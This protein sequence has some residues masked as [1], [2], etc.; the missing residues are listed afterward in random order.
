MPIGFT[1]VK[2]SASMRKWCLCFM[3]EIL[4]LDCMLVYVLQFSVDF[5]NLV[6]S[7][8]K[9]GSKCLICRLWHIF[10]F[11][12]DFQGIIVCYFLHI[13]SKCLCSLTSLI[14]FKVCRIYLF[15]G[16]L[17]FFVFPYFLSQLHC[18]LPII[19]LIFRL[20]SF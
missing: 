18:I 16:G 14:L 1:N 3:T 10:C 11:D 6:W 8:W 13:S 17:D 19:V 20:L 4:M 15:L 12:F 7:G 2:S 5:F 9:C